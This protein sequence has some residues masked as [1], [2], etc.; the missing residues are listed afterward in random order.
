MNRNN[1]YNNTNID[2]NTFHVLYFNYKTF[3]NEVYKV[4]ELGSGAD[5]AIQ[6]DDSFNPPN[7]E[8]FRKISKS[9]S[10]VTLQTS[11]R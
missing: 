10:M 7:D 1:I 3:M 11:I 2:K 6:K 5:K 8:K 4:K 9:F